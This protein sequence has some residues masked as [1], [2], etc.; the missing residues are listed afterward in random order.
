M[1]SRGAHKRALRAA[2]AARHARRAGKDGPKTFRWRPGTVA[3]REIRQL[4]KSTDFLIRRAP[5]RRLVRETA[6]ETKTNL[7]W[8]SS[9]MDAIQEAA[10]A[11]IVKLLEDSQ[12]MCLH[13]GRVTVMP[14]DMQIARRLR[15]ERT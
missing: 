8:Q 15:G 3:L 6:E 1:A 12:L 14:K 10:E 13:A 4:Q 2:K 9:A 7:R 5:F 11:Y